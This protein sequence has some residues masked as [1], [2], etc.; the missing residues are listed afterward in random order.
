MTKDRAK[1]EELTAAHN[2]LP[3]GTMVRV[4]HLKNHRTVVVR[5]IDRGIKPAG[6]I[7]DLCREAAEKLDMIHEGSA[8]VRL[9]VLPDNWKT[10][11][12][13]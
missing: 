5:I 13:W 8:R 3:F 6:P 11:R 9:E 10:S 2:T 4:T 1:P 12:K 7:I